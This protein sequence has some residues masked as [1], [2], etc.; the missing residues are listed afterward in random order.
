MKIILGTT[1]PYRIQAFKFLRIDFV[2]EGSKVD[3]SQVDRNN[4]EE[5]VKELS[6]LKAE[7]VAKNHNDAI[8]IGMDSVGYFNG[9]ILEKPKSREEGFERLKSLSGNSHQFYTGIHIIN[10]AT[11]KVVSRVVKTG[12][13]LRKFSEKEIET[14]LNQD[15]FFNTYALGYDPLEHYSSTFTEKIE[16]SY[17]NFLR[18]IPLEAVVGLLQEAGYNL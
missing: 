1:S 11:E 18:G 10:T 13:Y 3:E 4:P 12:I 2:A 16:G 8:V 9:K 17:N 15:K 6:K 14:Y 5:L 7:A